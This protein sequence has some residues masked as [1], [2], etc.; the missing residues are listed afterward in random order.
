MNVE[1]KPLAEVTGRAIEVLSRELGP[2][3]ALRFINQFTNGYG[4]YTT[5]REALFEG[6]TLDQIVSEIKQARE[7]RSSGK[8]SSATPGTP[9]DNR[10]CGVP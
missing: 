3:D 8:G 7:S 10:G 9:D 4:D 2:A 6:L 5:E 1:R